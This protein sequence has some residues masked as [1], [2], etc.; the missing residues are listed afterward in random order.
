MSQ[1]SG[2]MSQNVKQ[3]LQ[4]AGLSDVKVVPGSFLV[5]ATD[6][7]NNPVAMVITPDSFF[8]VTDLTQQ[9]TTGSGAS[10]SQRSSPGSSS[11]QPSGQK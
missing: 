9:S 2:S 7:N 6:K 4:Q 10:S 3:Q 5:H 1:Q 8:A 11:S